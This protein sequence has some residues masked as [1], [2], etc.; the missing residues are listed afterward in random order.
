MFLLK[1]LGKLDVYWKTGFQWIQ[2]INE[3]TIFVWSFFFKV[4]FC[5]CNNGM[6]TYYEYPEKQKASIY[7]KLPLKPKFFV[8]F[9]YFW[10]DFLFYSWISSPNSSMEGDVVCIFGK[11]PDWKALFLFKMKIKQNPV[12]PNKEYNAIFKHIYQNIR[13]SQNISEVKKPALIYAILGNCYCIFESIRPK[14]DIRGQVRF[15]PN[16]FERY[17]GNATPGRFCNILPSFKHGD[18]ISSTS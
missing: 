2:K 3:L 16:T 17:G 6:L 18:S 14:R 8:R 1:N 10:K 11:G 7:L 9:Y 12:Y 15:V 5:F 4:S 13:V